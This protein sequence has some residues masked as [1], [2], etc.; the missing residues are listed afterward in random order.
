M[1]LLF[2]GMFLLFLSLKINPYLSATGAIAFVFSSYF[3]IA[4]EAGHNSK[5]NA[6]AY[7]PA[8]IAGVLMCYRGKIWLG[9]GISM[10]FITLPN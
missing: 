10:L 5:I 9:A 1:F 2:L 3:F 8:V 6:I 4:L 7:V